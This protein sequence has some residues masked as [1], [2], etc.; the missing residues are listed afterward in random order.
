VTQLVSLAYFHLA[1]WPAGL[2]DAGRDRACVARP[3]CGRAGP[4]A[5]RDRRA[6]RV[7]GPG[8]GSARPSLAWPGAVG[9]AGKGAV[10]GTTPSHRAIEVGNTLAG[11][12][13]RLDRTINRRRLDLEGG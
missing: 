6:D 5:G 11:D 1:L 3:D 7:S 4:R 9:S 2:T 10:R 13:I 12:D 8:I